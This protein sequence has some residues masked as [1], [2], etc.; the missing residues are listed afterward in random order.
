MYLCYCDCSFLPFP[1]PLPFAT[2][3]L[4]R[5]GRDHITELKNTAPK[6]PFFFLKPPSS[7]LLP[8]EGPVLAPKGVSLHYE[9]E[10]ACVIGKEVRDLAPDDEKG[11][12]GAIQCESVRVQHVPATR[13]PPR[14]QQRAS[15]DTYTTTTM[16]HLRHY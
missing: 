2:A 15:M 4:I 6:Q 9:V 13:L 7:I 10:L 5:L 11:A 3:A 12:L 1:P 16:P 8:G 14:S